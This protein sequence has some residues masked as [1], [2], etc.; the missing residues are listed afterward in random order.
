MVGAELSLAPHPPEQEGGR[1]MNSKW[2][3]SLPW[4]TL[5]IK[6]FFYYKKKENRASISDD[7]ERGQPGDSSQS[8]NQSMK[9]SW[10]PFALPHG[11]HLFG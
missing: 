7:Q 6:I 5:I 2:K 3:N 4:N 1:Y 9:P 11:A 8:G 10:F